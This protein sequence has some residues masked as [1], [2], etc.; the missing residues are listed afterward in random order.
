[1]SL[2]EM[3]NVDALLKVS[4]VFVSDFF[5]FLSMCWSVD[6]IQSEAENVLKY[7]S[8]MR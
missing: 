5:F 6:K 2:S 7:V 3:C 4:Q 1:M 8:F